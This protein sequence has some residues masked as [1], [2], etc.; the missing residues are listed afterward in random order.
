MGTLQKFKQESTVATERVLISHL[1]NCAGKKIVLLCNRKI[2]NLAAI[3]IPA[4]CMFYFET[5]FRR[6]FLIIR[7]SRM[8]L[9]H[10]FIFTN[11]DLKSSKFYFSSRQTSN[12]FPM[13]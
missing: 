8:F 7:E 10:F 13:I 3:S 4:I 1:V 2:H 6:T 9:V 12:A 11:K 5:T